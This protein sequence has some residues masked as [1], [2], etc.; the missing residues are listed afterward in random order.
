MG[1]RINDNMLGLALR[2]GDYA[3]SPRYELPKRYILKD[4]DA[5]PEWVD[6]YQVMSRFMQLGKTEWEALLAFL[7]LD[8]IEAAEENGE[9][10]ADI[11]GLFANDY[12]DRKGRKVT[13]E[14][15]YDHLIKNFTITDETN[16]EVYLIFKV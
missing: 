1:K 2:S 11:T 10:E 4:V 14:Q 13:K 8:I 12:S 5:I 16:E 7:F 9:N 6:L 15:V 3:I